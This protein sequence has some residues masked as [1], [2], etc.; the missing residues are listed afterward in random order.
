MI[1]T[2]DSF[3]G[4]QLDVIILSC[5]R[6]EAHASGVGFVND[7]RRLNVAITRAKRALW[8]L[9]SAAT[10]QTS[11]VWRALLDD[12][13]QRQIIIEDAHAECAQ[14]YITGIQMSFLFS[15]RCSQS[16]DRAQRCAMSWTV[17]EPGRQGFLGCLGA[18][19]M[20]LVIEKGMEGWLRMICSTRR[21][22]RK[23]RGSWVSP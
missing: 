16:G 5:V 14:A 20:L 23:Q 3:Q 6:A 13:Q 11:P 7:V 4:K 21:L 1:E 12:A 10:L 17:L 18:L 22:L 15:E 9:G 2:V 8:I 19:T